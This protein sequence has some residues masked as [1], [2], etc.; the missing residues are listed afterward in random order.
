MPALFVLAM[1][2]HLLFKEMNIWKLSTHFETFKMIIEF[3]F[4]I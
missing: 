1:L 4:C 3:L 2:S